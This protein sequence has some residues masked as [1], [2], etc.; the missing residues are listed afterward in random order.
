MYWY[1]IGKSIPGKGADIHWVS[2]KFAGSDTL[3]KTRKIVCDLTNGKKYDS[4]EIYSSKISKIPIE[5]ITIN[6][7]GKH[8]SIKTGKKKGAIKEIRSDGSLKGLE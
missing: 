2:M 3:T 8:Y 6:I 5:L 1:K 7:S 4:G